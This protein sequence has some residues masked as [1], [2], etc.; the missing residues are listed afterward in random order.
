MINQEIFTEQIKK[1]K[2]S[3]QTTNDY[4][5]LIT[6]IFRYHNKLTW[7]EIETAIKETIEGEANYNLINQIIESQ[8]KE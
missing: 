8:E 7:N 1:F 4:L 2:N 5:A 3:K 6:I